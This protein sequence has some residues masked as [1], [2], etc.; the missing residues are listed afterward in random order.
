MKTKIRILIA[1]DQLLFIDAFKSLLEE[2][3]NILVIGGVLDGNEVLNF[4]EKERPDIVM[5]DLQMPVMNGEETLKKIKKE[6]PS[7]KVIIV[8]GLLEESL[9]SYY[10]S[11][12]A[13][14]VLA[15]EFNAGIIFDAVYTVAKNKHYFNK[16]EV[17]GMLKEARK[18]SRTL[19]SS[20]VKLKARETEILEL[21][22][23]GKSNKQI[24]DV[25]CI[26]ES[27]V[28]FHK[29][30]LFEK[31]KTVNCLQLISYA[32]QNNLLV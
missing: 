28:N 24:G 12:G 20:N 27:T 31:T 11:M 7:Q 25:L 23:K 3:E 17:I 9:I 13:H 14:A 4:L 21:L 6:F 8:S 18:K 16:P 26:T 29:K 19:L 15:K 5:L 10:M 30:S 2:D 22:S 1:D 32:Y